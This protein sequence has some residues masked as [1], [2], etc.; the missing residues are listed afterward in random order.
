[1]NE[2]KVD[3]LN[4]VYGSVDG[5]LFNKSQTTLIQYPAGK[6]GGYTIPSN[7]TTIGDVAFS[8]CTR[9]T[10]VT[11]PDNVIS[12]GN[13]AFYDCTNLTSLTMGNG[14]TSIGNLAYLG[15]TSLTSVTI[16][17]S[18]TSIGGRAFSGCTSLASLTI[19]N[20]VAFI[21]QGLFYDCTSLRGAYFLGN[22][23]RLEVDSL[24]SAVATAIVYYLPG[25]TGWGSTFGGRPTALWQP[26]MQATAER[27][28]VG[29]NAY[30]FTI[31]WASGQI[32]VVDA[33]TNLA[34]P[35]WS[36]LQTNALGSG[37]LDFR[38]SDWTN[39]PARFYR[40]RAP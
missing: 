16:G 1:L 28:G 4:S 37:P 35:V 31:T 26:R 6:D 22:A 34:R 23:P 38:D 17:S 27:F 24:F 36:P 5:V 33:C 29:T 12:I 10:T 9:L 25:T 7:V 18:V 13:L 19:P 32:V 11:I 14:V 40:L 20:S 15:C 3:A 8:S 2:I 39:H 30:G 21:A